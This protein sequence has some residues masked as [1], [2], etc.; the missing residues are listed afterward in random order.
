MTCSYD[1]KSVPPTRLNPS[2]WSKWSNNCWASIL[3]FSLFLLLG[4]FSAIFF[5]CFL[6]GLIL[7]KVLVS[8]CFH[9]WTLSELNSSNSQLRCLSKT[10]LWC[11]NWTRW[12]ITI[13]LNCSPPTVCSSPELYLQLQLKN[14]RI[15]HLYVTQSFTMIS[16]I[17]TVKNI[18]LYI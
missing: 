8:H 1:L 11:F 12:I 9:C 6:C 14:L 16:R 3:H 5:Q 18:L 7:Q 15:H 10:P 17:H 2:H 13:L 4:F